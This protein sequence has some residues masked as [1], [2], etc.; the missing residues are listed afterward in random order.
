MFIKPM[1]VV[2]TGSTKSYMYSTWLM[3]NKKINKDIVKK[4]LAFALGWFAFLPLIV[5]VIES[6][7]L[8]PLC[9][10]L[11]LGPPSLTN[12]DN[13]LMFSRYHVN[14]WTMCS[15]LVQEVGQ[16]QTE[17]AGGN[18]VKRQVLKVTKN[19]RGNRGII[20]VTQWQHAELIKKINKYPHFWPQ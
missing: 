13:I 18:Q 12:P 1:S 10:S 2:A 19:T 8:H 20:G 3:W 7:L 16:M 15:I 9:K 5:L 14:R 17:K 6:P 11:S 4:K